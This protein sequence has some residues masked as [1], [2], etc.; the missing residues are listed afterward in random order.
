M[1]VYT[2]MLGIFR[3]EMNTVLFGMCSINYNYMSLKIDRFILYSIPSIIF[4]P[5]LLL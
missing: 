3:C 5:F 1:D 2:H 4:I